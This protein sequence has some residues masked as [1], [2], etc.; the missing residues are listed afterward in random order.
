MEAFVEKGESVPLR[1]PPSA[2][3]EEAT[4][5]TSFISEQP[6]A[7]TETDPAEVVEPERRFDVA[8]LKLITDTQ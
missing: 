7:A 2:A 5:E 1:R 6:S 4:Q 3:D 8:V